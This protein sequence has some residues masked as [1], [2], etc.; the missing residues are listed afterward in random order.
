MSKNFTDSLKNYALDKLDNLRNSIETTTEDASEYIKDVKDNIE[1]RFNAILTDLETAR[2][3]NKKSF[4]TF[5]S[6][7][8]SLYKKIE[9][10]EISSESGLKNFYENY[11]SFYEKYESFIST[12]TAELI[13]SDYKNYPSLE[14]YLVHQNYLIT[15]TVDNGKISITESD[16]EIT[17]YI[18]KENI[19]SFDADVDDSNSGKISSGDVTV[20]K[21]YDGNSYS[22][23]SNKSNIYQIEY[24][25]TVYSALVNY[26]ANLQKNKKT[27]ANELC[28]EIKSNIISKLVLLNKNYTALKEKLNYIEADIDTF[29]EE[30]IKDKI[31]NKDFY[32]QFSGYEKIDDISNDDKNLNEL[33]GFIK[34][35][36]DESLNY[37]NSDDGLTYFI[38]NKV[39]NYTYENSN[40]TYTSGKETWTSGIENF[41]TDLYSKELTNDNTKI[42]YYDTEAKAVSFTLTGPTD[43][44]IFP[45]GE[46]ITVEISDGIE[47]YKIYKNLYSSLESSLSDSLKEAY[48]YLIGDFIT[49]EVNNTS[50]SNN[51]ITVNYESSENKLYKVVKS[52]TDTI[53]NKITNISITKSNANS[54]ATS[55]Y[56]T[57]LS[58]ANYIGSSTII[59]VSSFAGET[60]D[61]FS[62]FF[63]SDGEPVDDIDASSYTNDYLVVNEATLK[64][65]IGAKIYEEL[66]E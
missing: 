61:D 7:L 5:L 38:N 30:E 15:N 18:S 63:N 40:I 58:L 54:V 10:T 35:A 34:D 29:V 59:N 23:E 39:D 48:T 50:Y 4:K 41:P 53:G 36:Y 17:A 37:S 49:N 19:D 14:K 47:Y 45:P 31:N 56:N 43:E 52:I 55:I 8:S 51:I 16:D 66:T 60:H 2:E 13:N 25:L 32:H 42:I 44:I 24:P 27:E 6:E 26:Y 28:N 21:T 9:D 46:D 11:K 20:N 1:N 22:Y 64:T 65:Y 62:Y 3:K 12:D 57:Y 33:V